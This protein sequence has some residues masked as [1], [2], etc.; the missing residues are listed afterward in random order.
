MLPLERKTQAT[1]SGQ[2]GR[3]GTNDGSYG[4]CA[5]KPNFFSRRFFPREVQ[6]FIL[7]RSFADFP[8]PGEF[9]G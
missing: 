9:D 4:V 6:T 2:V 1:F 3:L 5:I 8:K 7:S